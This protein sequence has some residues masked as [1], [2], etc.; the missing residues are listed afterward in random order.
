[1]HTQMPEQ[2]DGCHC[3]SMLTHART[4]GKLSF[5]SLLSLCSFIKNMKFITNFTIIRNSLYV[6]RE[7]S[8]MLSL[9]SFSVSFT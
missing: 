3:S 2:E 5:L 6:K 7:I 1:M 9:S 4:S 8:P